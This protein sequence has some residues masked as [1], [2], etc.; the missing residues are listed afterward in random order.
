RY[1]SSSLSLLISM[2]GYLQKDSGGERRHCPRENYSQ[3]QKPSNE[4]ACSIFVRV[5]QVW[6]S[7]LRRIVVWPS[8]DISTS[9]M[10]DTRCRRT[11]PRISARRSTIATH[12]RS[13]LRLKPIW[14]PPWKHCQSRSH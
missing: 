2:R 3:R 6:K 7:R 5:P 12:A 9:E 1:I 14:K 8:T 10:Q 4:R 11:P 13:Q